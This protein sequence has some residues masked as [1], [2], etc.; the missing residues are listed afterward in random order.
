MSTR[1]AIENAFDTR[2]YE[3]VGVVNA[4]ASPAFM[5]IP[6]RSEVTVQL[7]SIQSGTPTINIEISLSDAA[8]ADAGTAVWDPA[9]GVKAPAT[10]I[11][12]TTAGQAETVLQ[13]GN[14]IR[15][16][17]ASGTGSATVRIKAERV[18]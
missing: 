1:T 7:M 8:D 15:P 17:V 16:I 2:L 12:L 9:T 6:T 3:F 18:R 10:D 14:L 5:A 4:D 13:S 11:A